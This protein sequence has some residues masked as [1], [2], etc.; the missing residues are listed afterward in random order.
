MVTR[1]LLVRQ[2]ASGMW[3]LFRQDEHRVRAGSTR[4]G[5]AVPRAAGP[6]MPS[7][8]HPGEGAEDGHADRASASAAAS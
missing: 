4:S 6:M 1:R 2:H 8:T 3:E 5:Y 7:A